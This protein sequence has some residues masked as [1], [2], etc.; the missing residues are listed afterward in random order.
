MRDHID[1]RLVSELVQ[2]IIFHERN[3]TFNLVSGNLMSFGEIA[4][5]I[6]DIFWKRKKIEVN[7]ISI[8]RNGPMP[9]DGYRGLINQKYHLIL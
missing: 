6:K 1:I 7:I 8:P 9:H 5:I 3:G 4:N 2:K